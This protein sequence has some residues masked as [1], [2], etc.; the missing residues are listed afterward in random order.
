MNEIKSI[1][2]WYKGIKFR[3]RLE[4]RWAVFFDACGIKYEYEPEGYEINGEK[5]LPDFYLP[6]LETYAEVKGQR[7]GYKYEI[8]KLQNFIKWGGPIK[9]IVILS[10]IPDPT[11][12]GMPH[13]PAYC[14]VANQV[15]SRWFFF[16]DYDDD[17]CEGHISRANYPVPHIWRAEDRYF[18]IES[19]SD[20]DLRYPKPKFDP[21]WDH[22]MKTTNNKVF[23]AY[24]KA[25]SARFEHGENGAII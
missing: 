23:T 22:W 5:Y 18:S 9:Q 17:K 6:E 11:I 7:L 1:E 21:Q 20:M 4:A 3:S 13:F 14:W 10:D 16:Q 25:R 12:M 8:L 2:T 15:D 19:R 24:K